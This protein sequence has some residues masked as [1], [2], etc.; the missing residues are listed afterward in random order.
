MTSQDLKQKHSCDDLRICKNCYQK[1]EP[2]HLCPLKIEKL[3]S[4]H[5]RLAFFEIIFDNITRKPLM[6]IILREE[7]E[8]GIFEQYLFFDPETSCT[9]SQTA[10]QL[11]FKYF[12]TNWRLE[13]LDFNLSIKSSKNNQINNFQTTAGVSLA[14][15]L[16]T[17]LLDVSFPHTTYICQD[18][19]SLNLVRINQI[20]LGFD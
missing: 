2:D 20:L 1:R 11:K 15:Q 6:A 3:L 18:S 17:Y 5:T 12:E 14:D 8:R 13:N 7:K 10:N 9:N 19:L 4:F 16:L